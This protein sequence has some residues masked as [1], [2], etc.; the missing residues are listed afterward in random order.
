[1]NLRQPTPEWFSP[2]RFPFDYDRKATCP[3]WESFLSEVLEGDLELVGLLQEWFGYLLLPDNSRQKF[4]IMTGTGANGKSVV[5]TVLAAMLGHENVSGISLEEFGDPF[6]LNNLR[7][8]LANICADISPNPG[9]EGRLKQFVGGDPVHANRK[10]KSYVK[11]VPK[12]RLVFSANELPQFKDTSGG[13]WRRLMVLPFNYVVPETE[14]DIHLAEKL[15]GELPGIFNW[16]LKGLRR[17][18]A[19][20][21][22]QF[23]EPAI[24][25]EAVDRLRWDADF[26]GK[27]V[28]ERCEE[29]A[30]SEFVVTQDLYGPYAEWCIDHGYVNLECSA[31]TKRLKVKFPMT[32]KGR[33]GSGERRHGYFGVRLKAPRE[34]KKAGLAA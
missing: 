22:G 16:A 31:F 29:T 11:F 20:P 32:R 8:K 14:R 17:L 34:V 3:K 28:T 9:N 12:A 6:A 5:L 33:E 24:C 19:N 18:N 10:H 23:S 13:I 2:I 30:G 27:F 4:L 25:R 21:Q 26:T 15:I 1:V 7:G